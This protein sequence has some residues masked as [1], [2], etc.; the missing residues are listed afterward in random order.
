MLTSDQLKDLRARITAAGQP[1]H[2]LTDARTFIRG[3]NAAIDHVE[4]CIREVVGE[5]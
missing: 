5:T 2:K 4:K 3:F 1:E